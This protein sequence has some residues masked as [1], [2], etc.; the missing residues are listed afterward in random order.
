MGICAGLTADTVV[1]VKVNCYIFIVRLS[2]LP[3]FAETIC[4]GY[5][6]AEQQP[7]TSE[8]YCGILLQRFFVFFSFFFLSEFGVLHDLA[9]TIRGS[10]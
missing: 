9:A 3:W 4:Q 8:K 5:G 7:L 10:S 6:S 1:T 2:S